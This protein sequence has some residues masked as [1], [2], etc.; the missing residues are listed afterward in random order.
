MTIKIETNTPSGGPASAKIMKRLMDSPR[1]SHI[2]HPRSTVPSA[3]QSP[4]RPGR[5]RR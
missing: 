3:T 4:R 5:H 1:A 2:R